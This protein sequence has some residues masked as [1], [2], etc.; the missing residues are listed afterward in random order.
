[1]K[2]ILISSRAIGNSLKELLMHE[3]YNVVVESDIEQAKQLIESQKFS[4]VISHHKTLY[5]ED[6]I[7]SETISKLNS[8]ATLIYVLN[9]INKQITEQAI[10]FGAY[11]VLSPPINVPLLINEISKAIEYY[12]SK[13]PIKQEL[14]AE[15]TKEIATYFDKIVG[16]SPDIESI[17]EMIRVVAPSDARVIITGENGTGKELVARSIFALSKRKDKPFVE[18]NCAAIPQELIESEMFGHEKGSF[19]SAVKLRKGK[20]EQANG[21]TLFL[22]EIGDMCL[23]A[24]AK[25][26]RALQEKKITRVGGDEEIQVDVR[27]IAATNKNLKEEISNGRFREDLYHR[28][29]VI[30]IK[31]PSLNQRIMDIPI[32]IEAFIKEICN[33]YS[34]DTK[35]IEPMA[36]EMLQNK[37]W[38]GNIRELH[39]VVERLVILGSNP[40]TTEN[41][42]K[43]VTF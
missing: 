43:F 24:Q 37:N 4:I 20:F 38:T 22:D 21:G 33:Y 18:V 26:L 7:T 2:T 35:T 3:N 36:V 34:Y 15:E 39:N 41:V 13:T 42:Q 27:V 28:I 19:T 16:I 29:S 6:I 40:I 32:L 31:V 10:E 30:E 5:D 1:M 23:S 25:V 14:Q 12:N 17:R 9:K 11:A 8:S